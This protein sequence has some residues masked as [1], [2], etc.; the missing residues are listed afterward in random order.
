[1]TDQAQ[2]RPLWRLLRIRLSVRGDVSILWNLHDH[3]DYP[4][5]IEKIKAMNPGR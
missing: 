2:P 1:M 3:A 4:R 5:L